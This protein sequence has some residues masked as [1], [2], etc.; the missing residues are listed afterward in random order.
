MLTDSKYLITF[1]TVSRKLEVNLEE[2]MLLETQNIKHDIEM[3]SN[4]KEK[5]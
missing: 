3:T 5:L 2:S 1:L 4:V